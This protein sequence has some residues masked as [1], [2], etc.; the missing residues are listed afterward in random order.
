[1]K[2]TD[3]VAGDSLNFSTSTPDYPASAGWVLKHRLAPRTAAPG[4]NPI[5][6]VS[7]PDGDDHRT[8]ATAY[9]TALWVPATYSWWAWVERDT[10]RYTVASGELVVRADPRTA[11][12]GV[13]A[14]TENQRALDDARAAFRSW[15]PTMRRYKIGEREREFN[16]VSEILALIRYLEA[17]VALETGTARPGAGGRIFY[18]FK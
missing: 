14:R 16:A 3:L 11:A 8:Q 2:Q 15:N 17:Q 18:R 6:L 13:D 7:V 9:G 5:D 10:E 12:V 1:M 4:A